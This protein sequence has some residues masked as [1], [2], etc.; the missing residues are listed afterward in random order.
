MN[1]GTAPTPIEAGSGAVANR[2][3][4]ALAKLGLAQRHHA[5]RAAGARDLT[6]TQ[7]QALALLARLREEEATVGGVAE[8]LAVSAPCASDAVATLEAKGLVAKRR[9]ERDRRVV[10]LSLTRRGRREAERAALWP[11]FLARAVETLEP[12]ERAALLSALVKTIRALQETGEIPV[13]RMCVTCVHFRPR[14]HDDARRPHHCAFVDAP[15]GDDALRVECADHR[16]AGPGERDARWRAWA[17][18]TGAVPSI[19]PR[20]RK[21]ARS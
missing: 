10:R 1:D 20:R 11:D 18:D 21:E 4:T 5:W 14:V 12:G 2:V 6:P 15:F 17:G 3:A 19:P 16:E 9:A 13:S 8:G 7:G